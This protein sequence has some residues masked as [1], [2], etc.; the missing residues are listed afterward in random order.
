MSPGGLLLNLRVQ[1]V[2]HLQKA[3]QSIVPITLKDDH[4]QRN[5][6]VKQHPQ[7]LVAHLKIVRQSS[8]YTM[9]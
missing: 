8:L 6:G 3:R 9:E 7:K 1:E 4:T 2:L 5:T